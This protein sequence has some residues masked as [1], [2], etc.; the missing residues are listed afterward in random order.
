MRLAR[1]AGFSVV[2]PLRSTPTSR[3]SRAAR[4][5]PRHLCPE[6]RERRVAGWSTGRPLSDSQGS[7]HRRPRRPPARRY[8]WRTLCFIGRAP[9]PLRHDASGIRLVSSRG[10]CHEACCGRERISVQGPSRSIRCGRN[11]R[12]RSARKRAFAVWWSSTAWGNGTSTLAMPP[13]SSATVT[14]PARQ[15]PGRQP[16]R[17]AMLSI[18]DEPPTPAFA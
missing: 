17:R 2:R 13:A 5:V 11:R 6:A 3:H 16:A 9:A 7:Q 1:A 8:T 12:P 4:R 14:A 10:R 18:S 15:S